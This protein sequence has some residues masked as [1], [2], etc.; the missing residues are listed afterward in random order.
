MELKASDKTEKFRLLFAQE[1]H[2]SNKD[3]DALKLPASK[4]NIAR[5]YNNEGF[6]VTDFKLSANVRA[7]E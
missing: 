1:T 7:L 6:S 5:L 4:F 2:E 3:N